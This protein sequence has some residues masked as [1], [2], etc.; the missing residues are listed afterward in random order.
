MGIKELVED[1]VGALSIFLIL[2][3]LLIIGWVIEGK[4]YA[5]TYKEE[6]SQE[7]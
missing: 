7:L 1:I 6:L 4:D 2:Y 3:L 5:E